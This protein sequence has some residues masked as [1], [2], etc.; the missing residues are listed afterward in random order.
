MKTR[1]GPGSEWEKAV[2]DEASGGIRARGEEAIGEVAQALLENPLFSQA[3]GRAL[4]AGE[5]A[6]QVQKQAMGALD[7]ANAG[8]LDQLTRRIRSL[9]D[10]LERVED[11]LDAISAD[12]AELRKARDAESPGTSAG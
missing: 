5:R 9:S 8:D 4:G 6:M 1:P 12:L 7:V 3:L 11:S 2:T 10:R